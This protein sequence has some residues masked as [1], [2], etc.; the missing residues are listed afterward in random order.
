MTA[1]PFAAGFRLH[2]RH[3]APLDG[4]LLPSGRC[5]VVE[6]V[7]TGH[8]SAASSLE[9]LTRGYP[10]ARIEWPAT[11]PA[12]LLAHRRTPPWPPGR[13]G[14]DQLTSDDLDR[15]YGQLDRAEAA[16]ARILRWCDELDART[17]EI[18]ED[19]TR[20]NR[21]ATAVR[22]TLTTREGW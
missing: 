18:T 20:A 15:L 9:D 22:Y 13:P 6:D 2:L 5:L 19:P 10:D 21:T 11:T 1:A 4:I 7:E 12:A 16:V 3:G 14:I 8:V 17:R